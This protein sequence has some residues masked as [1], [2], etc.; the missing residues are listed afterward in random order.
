[1]RLEL[2]P[3][4]GGCVPR[5]ISID[6]QYRYTMRLGRGNRV[7]PWFTII[8]LSDEMLQGLRSTAGYR[9]GETKPANDEH[10]SSRPR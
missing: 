4:E 7:L 1:M 8:E 9:I 5:P 10:D 2:A 6:H 3:S